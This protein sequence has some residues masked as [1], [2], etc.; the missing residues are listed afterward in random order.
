[1]N[2]GRPY[3]TIYHQLHSFASGHLE[4]FPLVSPSRAFPVNAVTLGVS[5]VILNYFEDVN[6]VSG[7][8]S[9][10]LQNSLAKEVGTLSFSFR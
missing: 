8:A 3:L 10:G 1:M 6:G 5:R 9:G 4:N 7:G 2:L